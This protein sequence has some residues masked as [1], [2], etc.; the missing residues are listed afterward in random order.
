[1]TNADREILIQNAIRGY[2]QAQQIG[3]QRQIENAINVMENTFEAICLWAVPGTEDLRQFI[4][5]A[6]A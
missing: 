2:K 5:A 1:M 3:D 6:R 4:L